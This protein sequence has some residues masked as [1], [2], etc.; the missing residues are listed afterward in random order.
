MGEKVNQWLAFIDMERGDLLEMAKK[1]NKEIK[2]A[3]EDYEVLTGDAELKR[4]AEIRHMSKLEENS[5]L[6]VERTKG[7]AIGTKATQEKIAKK[8]IKIGVGIE[9]IIEATGLTK[10]EIEKLK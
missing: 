10:D 5:A 1:E 2:K 6:A 8:L 3:V 9:S 7:I 4:L